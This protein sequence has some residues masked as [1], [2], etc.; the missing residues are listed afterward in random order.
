MPLMR[1]RWIL[2]GVRHRGQPLVELGMSFQVA[3][4]SS[5][6]QPPS[7]RKFRLATSTV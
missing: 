3:S 5:S 1:V 7:R 6:E 2:L 4:S